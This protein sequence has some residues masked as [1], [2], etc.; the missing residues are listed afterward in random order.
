VTSWPDA[1]EKQIGAGLQITPNASKIFQQLG[2]FDVLEAKA[3]EPTFLQVR[4]Y[5]DGKILSRTDDFNEDMRRKYGAPF[6]DLH[7]VDVQRA[8]ADRTKELGARVRLGSRV[9]DIDFDKPSVKLESGEELQADL[10][11]AADG[12]WSKCR[13]RFLASKGKED[14]PLPT[15]DLA[16]RIVLNLDEVDDPELCGPHTRTFQCIC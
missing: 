7:R 5:S 10:I 1:D 14:S 12:L 11:V 6:L 15:G 3:A 13:E 4:R 8:L 9:A 2:V 16:Y